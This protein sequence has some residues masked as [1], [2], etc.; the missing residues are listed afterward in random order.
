LLLDDDP[1]ALEAI[2]EV[3]RD[4][5]ADVKACIN[6]NEARG[7]IEQG[8]HPHLLIMD[9]RIDGTLSGVDIANRLRAQLT[10]PPPVIIVT[11]DTAADTLAFLSASGHQWLI[12]PVEPA[13]LMQ[14]ITRQLQ[15]AD[16]TT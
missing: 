8:F 16:A 14:A 13:T 7:A 1:N 2:T 9:L 5:G 15:D 4:L 6:E 11:G 10:P 12:K 3:V